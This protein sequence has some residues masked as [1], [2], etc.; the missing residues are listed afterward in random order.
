MSSNTKNIDPVIP[1]NFE[2]NLV[3]LP[4]PLLVKHCQR[5]LAIEEPQVWAAIKNSVNRK[6]YVTMH[7]VVVLVMKRKSDI[8]PMKC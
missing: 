3:Y 4:G 2:L 7:F 6:D 1:K 8:P 5:G